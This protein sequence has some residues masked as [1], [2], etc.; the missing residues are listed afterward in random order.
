MVLFVFFGYKL[1]AEKKPKINT[2]EQAVS[3]DMVFPTVDSSVKVDLR[4]TK[5]GEAVL[6]VN[7]APSGTESIEFEMSY[8]V[9]NEDTGDGGGTVSQGAIGKCYEVRGIWECGEPSA[10]GRKIIL[11]TCSSGVCR[12]HNISGPIRISLKFSGSYGDKMFTK[13]YEI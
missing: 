3:S 1:L 5:K 9:I 11:G 6:S 4:S 8:L 7:N 12:Y 2:D 13:E 10:S